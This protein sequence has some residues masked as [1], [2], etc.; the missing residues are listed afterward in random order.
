MQNYCDAGAI[1]PV[2]NE[3][4][5]LPRMPGPNSPQLTLPSFQTPFGQNRKF[6]NKASSEEDDKQSSSKDNKQSQW[7][8]TKCKRY[9]T[10]KEKLGIHVKA[11]HSNNPELL[12]CSVIDCK[13]NFRRPDDRKR[14]ESTVHGS[15]QHACKCGRA[16]G[17][18]DAL[19]R[20]EEFVER[21]DV[22]CLHYTRHKKS[23]MECVP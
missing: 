20:Y 16:F 15:P 19:Q 12:S 10:R 1:F 14:H 3:H 18:K 4:L 22:I 7:Q 9:F 23:C 11:V 5:Q 6:C 8:C 17:R 13:S 21:T 2:M